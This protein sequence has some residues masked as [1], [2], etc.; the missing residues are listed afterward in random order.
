M[1]PRTVV[2]TGASAGVGRACA[3]AF[4]ARG[5]TVVLLARGERGLEAAADEVR[6]RG[7]SPTILEVDVADA[8][9]VE[10]AAER[11]ETEI[12]P[13]DLWVNCAFA[14]VFGPFDRIGADEFKRVTEVT[15]L[16]YVHGTRAALRHMLDRDRGVIVQVGSALAYRGIPLQSAYCGAKHAIQGFNESLRCE[17]LH[18]R[19]RVRV[20]MVQLPAVNTPQF[21]WARN[22][23]RRRPR[24]VPPIYEPEVA[25]DAVVFA[26]D[27]PRRREYWVGASTAKTLVGDKF[28]PGLLDRY[29]ARKGYGA[30]QEDRRRDGEGNLWE[31]LDD[32]G[33]EFG[34]RGRFGPRSRRLAPQVWLSRHH[35]TLALL[36]GLA[37]AGAVAGLIGGRRREPRSR[38]PG[39][40]G[41]GKGRAR[42]PAA[43]S[44]TAL[45]TGLAH[46]A[47]ASSG[48]SWSRSLVTVKVAF[49]PVSGSA[50]P[51]PPRRRGRGGRRTGTGPAG[52]S[53]PRR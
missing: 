50:S 21:D 1:K 18:G 9:A 46:R 3:R 20:T 52:R 16:G 28:A 26:A 47:L 27:H 32:T 24:P 34:A 19:S 2:V 33:R 49:S 44:L 45:R 8:E 13:I 23:M 4:G 29:L 41:R 35:G 25:A 31:P 42:H 12:G 7:G 17:L 10:A 14:T 22:L 30:Q 6:E 40:A 43:Q 5:D 11:V 36:A 48:S 53:R 51:C 39:G 38:P 15:Y 37:A